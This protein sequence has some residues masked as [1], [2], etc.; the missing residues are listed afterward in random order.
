MRGK[1]EREGN[2]KGCEGRLMARM[3]EGEDEGV[4][5]ITRRGV[6]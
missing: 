4:R 5:V 3:C 1:Y 2:G 6:G